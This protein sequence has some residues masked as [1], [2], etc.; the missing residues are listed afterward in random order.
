MV[1]VTV[2][3]TEPLSFPL[4]RLADFEETDTL[5]FWV[6]LGRL[7]HQTSRW[8][9]GRC[10]SNKKSAKER[11]VGLVAEVLYDR[12]PGPKSKSARAERAT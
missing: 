6:G 11:L 5:H 4:S 10:G 3:S 7:P 12:I 1:R 9:L 8:C 2:P